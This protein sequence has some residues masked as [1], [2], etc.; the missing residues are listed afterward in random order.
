MRLGKT[1]RVALQVIGAVGL[2]ALVAV[3]PGMGLVL[4]QLGI[5]KKFSKPYTSTL[6]SRLKQRGYVTTEVRDGKKYIR[7]TALGRKR[8]EEY[9]NQHR[10]VQGVKKS[11]SWDGK[12]RIVTFD[13]PE[14]YRRSRDQIRFELR[15]AGFVQLHKSVWVTPHQCEE[16]IA[17][18]KAD[19]HV[20]KSLLYIVADKIEYGHELRK[21]FNLV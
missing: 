4:K 9:Q 6:A 16:F 14:R 17:L 10:R 11:K 8:L 12:W 5:Q 19:Q 3:A 21:K 2:I 18:L 1:E 13:I 15:E 20:G 7:L